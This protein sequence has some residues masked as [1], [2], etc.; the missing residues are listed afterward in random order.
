MF[1][2]FTERPDA[3]LILVFGLGLLIAPVRRDWQRFAARRGSRR[4]GARAGFPARLV[5][6][7]LSSMVPALRRPAESAVRSIVAS[8]KLKSASDSL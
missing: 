3:G 2:R 8:Q 5:E 6:W 1:I 7:A 4:S